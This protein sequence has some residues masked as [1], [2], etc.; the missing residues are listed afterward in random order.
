MATL[1]CEQ[2]TANSSESELLTKNTFL[3]VKMMKKGK[4]SPQ[5][6]VS[7]TFTSLTVWNDEYFT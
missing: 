1:V 4:T 6:Q 2:I 3:T 5:A 7:Q